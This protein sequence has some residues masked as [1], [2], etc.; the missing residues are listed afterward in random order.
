MLPKLKFAILRQAMWALGVIG[1]RARRLKS[2]PA[3]GAVHRIAVLQ[4]GGIGDM[5]LITAALRELARAYPHAR[6][7]VVCSDR[8][9]AA[10]LSRFPFVDEVRAFNIYAMDARAVSTGRFWTESFA[11][12]RWLRSRRFGLLVNFHNPFLVDWFLVEFLLVA[13]SKARFTVGVNPR[14]LPHRSVY[15]RW[16]SEGRLDGHHYK[17]FFLDVIGLLGVEPLSRDTTFPL[18]TEDAAYAHA[19]L[20]TQA[21]EPPAVAVIHPGGS[22]PHNHWPTAR[23]GELSRALSRR[24]LQVIVVGSDADRGKGA[25][26]AGIDPNARNLAGTASIP[27]TAA[28]IARAAVF[29]GNDSG[30]FHIAVAVNTP[31]VG[32]VGGGS[33]RFH[34]YSRE[35]IRVVKKATSCAPCQD[36]TCPSTECMQRIEVGDVLAAVDQLLALSGSH[37]ISPTAFAANG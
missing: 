6:I 33:P 1:A 10:F 7:S 29:V 24:R 3:P 9:N 36:R 13:F 17:D 22:A 12:A 14:F 8:G 25:A 2:P 20:A 27:Q 35:S 34:L 18:G 5:V 28:L 26:I 16:I 15:H 19:L 23:Y 4:F 32:L 31:A 11:M 37:P 30:P 21:V